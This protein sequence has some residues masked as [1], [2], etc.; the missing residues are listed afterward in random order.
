MRL[1]PATDRHVA[2]QRAR[3]NLLDQGP[4]AALP[5]IEP[6]IGQSWRRCIAQGKQP[7]QSIVFAPNPMASQKRFVDEHHAL[8]EAAKPSLQ[9]LAGLVAGIGYFALLTN[10]QGMVIDVAGAVDRSDPAAA[11]VAQIGVD[12]SEHS[13]GTSAICTAL[14]EQHPVWLHQHEHFFEATSVYSCAGAPLFDPRGACI[15]MLDLT[16]IRVREQRPLIHLVSQYALEIERSILKRE[17]H[18]LLLQIRWPGQASGATGYGLLSVDEAGLILGSDQVSRQMLPDLHSLQN[19]PLH[20]SDLFASA[21]GAFF[22]RA[23]SGRGPS[24]QPLW[25]GLSLLVDA[26]PSDNLPLAK[27]SSEAASP[28]LKTV[29]SELIQ[30]ALLNAKGNVELAAKRLGIGRATLY[31][32]LR[33]PH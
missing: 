20:L 7:S 24:E 5:E 31:R 27:R 15:G 21:T 18:A 33:R 32:K 26:L 29:Q 10:A 8:I 25:S 4:Q 13:A 30:Q 2:V 19:E 22:D 12:L 16:G 11:S 3:R 1:D 6:W 17:K 28:L 14:S 9:N 23:S